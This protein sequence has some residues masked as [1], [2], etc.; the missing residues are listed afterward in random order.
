MRKINSIISMI[1][2]FLILFTTIMPGITIGSDP[3][4][5]RI[6]SGQDLIQ[7]SEDCSYDR[8]SKDTRVF[9]DNDIDLKGIDFLPI[10][11][12]AGTF[13]GQGYSI[14]GLSISVEGSNQG[15]FRYLQEGAIIK[16]LSVQGVVKPMG[17]KS[18]IG[19]LVGNNKGIVENC[20]FSGSVKG[21]DIVG[22]LIGWNSITGKVINSSF[23][24][25]IH[26]EAK[27]GGLV[28]YNAGTILRCTNYS[29]VNTT[30]ED[31][32]LGL[33]DITIDNISFS[34]I[35]LDATDIGGIAGINK[36][37][38]QN[39]INYGIVGYPHVG[40]NVGGIAGRQ[41]GYITTSLNHGKVYGRKEVA[42][43]VGQI[44]PHISSTLKLSKLKK[45]QRELNLL[46][47]SITKLIGHGKATINI[48]SDNLLFIQDN[49]DRSKIHAESLIDQTE[50][51]I[52]KDIDQI[53]KISVIGVET[54]DRLIPITEDLGKMVED[55]A[56][57]MKPLKSA[58][59]NMS[60]MMKETDYMTRKL[61]DLAASLGNSIG[62]IIEI[63][64]GLEDSYD[65][66]EE[67]IKLLQG[68]NMD[69][70][71]ELEG[72]YEDI[73]KILE[74]LQ[75]LDIAEISGLLGD[76]IEN[77]KNISGDITKEINSLKPIVNDLKDIMRAIDDTGGYMGNALDS[78]IEAMDIMEEGTGG[79][80]DIIKGTTDILTFLTE[81]GDLKFET[82]DDYYQ[83]TKEDLYRSMGD[84]SSSLSKFIED[85]KTEGNILMDDIQA[86]SDQLFTIMNLMINMIEE[87]TS[88]DLV[89]QEE[90]VKDVS[91]HDIDK[92]TEGKVSD[93]KNF[94]KIEGDLNVGGIA[95]GMSIE[96]IDPEVDLDLKG[97]ISYNTIFET[98]ATILRCENTGSIIGK[99]DNV[100]GIV[101]NMTL[102][103][104]QDCIVSSSVG[105]IDGNY[106][107]G[108]AGR[109]DAAI[110]S[111][112]SRSTLEGG[113]YV[114]GISGFAKE[115]TNSYSLVKVSRSRACVG[116][117]AG[118][119]D[120]N[121]SIKM[122]YFVSD[123]LR[124]IDGISY[125]DKAQ[126]ITYEEL[127][128]I[129]NIPNV[130]RN[131]KLNFW[132]D[133]KIL[134][135]IDF[136]YGDSISQ[137]NF[138]KLPFKEGHYGSWEEFNMEELSFDKD[139]H[140]EYI[141]YV[142]I[143][144]SEEKRDDI[145]PIVLVE[146]LFIEGDYLTLAKDH[147]EGPILE[148]QSTDLEQWN[149]LIP[150]DGESNHILRF[151]PLEN[152]KNLEVYI[153][154][155]NRWEKVKSQW[156]GKYL[157]FEANGN[158]IRFSIIDMGVSYMKY[159][160]LIGMVFLI[161]V[162]ITYIRKNKI[163]MGTG[164]LAPNNMRGDNHEENGL[165]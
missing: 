159:I 141:P 162:L 130:F 88:G 135:T 121:S 53:N 137:N 38:I 118:N 34:K 52:N 58:M 91:R 19:G 79:M 47:S 113:N 144:E 37:I 99:K 68:V 13:D 117:I 1:I 2:I 101:G 152:K 50:S 72:S 35:F 123:Q 165:D 67:I 28:G 11:I 161:M 160:Y 21:R 78:I 114:G 125:M 66:I 33:E 103:Y 111:S 128:A 60:R 18:S 77:I 55:M 26:G 29:S 104:I 158:D 138:P 75:E 44:E 149:V 163:S 63:S 82:S 151:I 8:W 106:V 89:N 56:R 102:G 3:K 108:I 24:G 93:C 14:T 145:L 154:S 155:E 7:L 150:D 147:G 25:I 143:L 40:Y 153:F 148:K 83:K 126:P 39:S 76:I 133:D 30:V 65:Y 112:Y 15:L 69:E 48:T 122:N 85:I 98:R 54:L 6:S 4:L 109:S 124:G 32:K 27:V 116:A 45:L 90:I 86:V 12:F 36:G 23:N 46:D 73:S 164:L 84:V 131:F 115:I 87:I 97:K 71:L 127:M 42:G 62:N 105:S 51:M 142:T 120:A 132:V 74:L 59:E 9:L 20:S 157:V 57:A 107:G 5:V 10:P 70:T 100:G 64:E 43:I 17:E 136:N 129:A 80:D 134:E 92:Q 81:N 139:I 119:V 61:K 31:Q 16:N 94:G 110:V 140:A 49:I 95:G 146:G 96:L 41:S 156:D 22:G